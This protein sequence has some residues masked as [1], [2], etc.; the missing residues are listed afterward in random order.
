MMLS[1]L[2][3]G[4]GDVGVAAIKTDDGTKGILFHR[5]KDGEVGELTGHGGCR[6]EN[7]EPE[8]FL[9]IVSSSADS[10]QVVIDALEEA[11]GLFK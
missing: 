5:N 8:V 2:I 1:K 7:L 6:T 10:I 4:Y 9:E 11:K 3:L